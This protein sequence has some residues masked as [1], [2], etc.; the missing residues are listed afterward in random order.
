MNIPAGLKAQLDAAFDYRG[1]VTVRLKD[2]GGFE[3]FLYNRR[4]EEGWVELFVK[5]SEE[6]RRVEV[7]EIASVELTGENAA[8]P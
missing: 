4:Y 7:S 5:N 1:H 6:R 8:K 3:G 2:G